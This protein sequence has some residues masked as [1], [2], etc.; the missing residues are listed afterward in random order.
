MYSRADIEQQLDRDYSED[1]PDDTWDI[2]ESSEFRSF[3]GPDGRPFLKRPGNEGRLVFSLNVDGFNPYMNKQSGKKVTSGAVYMVCLN[4][5]PSM[6]YKVENMF[7]AGVIPGPREPSLHQ[8]N[9]LLRPLVDD[10]LYLWSPGIFLTKTH[11]HANGRRVRCALIP[12]VCDL[13]AA[14]R[15]TGFASYSSRHFCSCCHQTSDQINDLNYK[16][17]KLRT[18]AEH[19][20]NANDWRDAPSEPAREK[21]FNI[22]GIRWSELLRLP[23]WDPSRFTVI[24]PMHTFYL[25]ILQHHCRDIWGMDVRLADGDGTEP[26][27][28]AGPTEEELRTGY[29]ILRNGTAAQ[30]GKLRVPILRQLCRDTQTMGYEGKKKRLLKDLLAYVCCH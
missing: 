26:K 19:L 13:P 2:W 29:E 15:I 24:D 3:N 5:P 12:V 10:L 8:I 4:L 20:E 9:H 16:S 25:R 18:Y 30:L 14:R 11:H 22:H 6:R 28:P 17:W 23:Y 27:Q 1:E 7:L 21:L